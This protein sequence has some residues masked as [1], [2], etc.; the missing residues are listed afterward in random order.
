[1]LNFQTK[2]QVHNRGCE[3]VGRPVGELV[4]QMDMK[5]SGKKSQVGDAWESWFGVEKNNIAGPD[6]AEAGV[7]L[8]ATP[9]KDTRNGKSAKERLVL[10]IINYV[11]GLL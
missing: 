4:K 8:K 2:E 10:N 5:L 1:M 3:A 11:E 9:V 6:L 7:E